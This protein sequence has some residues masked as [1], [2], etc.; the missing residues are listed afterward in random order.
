MIQNK[1]LRINESNQTNIEMF[2]NS[3]LHFC[4][5]GNWDYK[6]DEYHKQ[7]TALFKTFLNS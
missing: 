2:V 4:A 3:F 1:S 5:G 6:G 7:K